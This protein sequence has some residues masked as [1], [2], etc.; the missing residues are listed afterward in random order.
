M[1]SS[2]GGSVFICVDLAFRPKA[3]NFPFKNIIITPLIQ[4]NYSLRSINTFG[5]NEKARFYQRVE[6]LDDLK[7][8]LQFAAKQQLPLLVLGGGSNI[9]LT[10]DFPGLVI[11]I[12]TKGVELVFSSDQQVI[13]DVAAGENWHQF[14]MYSLEKQWFG[15]EN[16][17]LIPGSVGAAPMQN[18]GAYGVEVGN[19]IDSVEWLDIETREINR[20]L[21]ADCQFGYRDS[22]FK[23][24]LK[25]KAIICSVRFH[26]SLKPQTKIEYGDIRLILEKWG[27]QQPTPNDVSKAIIEIR[28][29]K[30]PNPALVGNAGSFFKNPVVSK[31]IFSGLSTKYPQVPHYPVDENQVKIPA[32]WLIETAGW[33]GKNFGNY[34]VHDRQ[35]LVLVNYGGATGRQIWDLAMN[36]QIDV[37]EKFGIELQPEVNLI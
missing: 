11:H 35:A 1:L 30:L 9:L 22:I 5:L 21:A 7:N 20:T 33:K 27:I 23:Q 28:Q 13:V 37:M 3:P 8:A 10:K 6:S 2:F 24:H 14:V 17:S 29:S 34:G 16:L 15:L 25:D 18:I 19:L 4:E 36:I 31:L 26:L 32:A 12:E